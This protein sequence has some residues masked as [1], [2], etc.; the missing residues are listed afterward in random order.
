[1]PCAPGVEER[2]H[3]ENW[4]DGDVTN[5]ALLPCLLKMSS[6]VGTFES[7]RV[8]TLPDMRVALGVERNI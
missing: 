1:M 5:P 6:K 8:V 3:R 7:P 4:I 2:L